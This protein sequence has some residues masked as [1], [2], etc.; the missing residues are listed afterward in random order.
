MTTRVAAPEV[1]RTGGDE[2]VD[3]G[4]EAAP[5][6]FPVL[7]I[8]DTGGV[9]VPTRALAMARVGYEIH[10]V[11]PRPSGIDA[12]NESVPQGGQWGGIRRLEMAARL[13]DHGRRLKSAAGEVAHI[14][15]ASSLGAWLFVASGDRRPLVVSVMGGDILFDEQGNPSWAARWLIRQ[16]LRRADF[17]TAKSE[18]LVERLV[19]LGVPKARMEKVFWGVDKDL[20]RPGDANRCK[21]ELGLPE[22]SPVIFSPR[23]LKPFYRTDVLV[24]ALPDVLARFPNARL[25]ISEYEADPTYR[26]E[27]KDLARKLGIA[28]AVVFAGSIPHNRMPE[29][30]NAADVAVG[31][32]PSDGFPQTVFEAM[33]CGTPN[34]VARLTRYEE[35]LTDGESALFVDPT[36]DGVARGILSVLDD[37]ELTERLRRNGF[38]I[39]REKA[40]LGHEAARVSEIY[41]RLHSLAPRPPLPLFTRLAAWALL[42][43]LAAR[44]FFKAEP[45]SRATWSDPT[46]GSATGAR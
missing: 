14:H 23:I 42:G 29:Y 24:Q 17:V 21:R 19:E 37:Q 2:V 12:L 11:T 36:G 46:T 4:S 10:A 9:H 32:P 5:A 27:I 38:R 41:Q 15:Y 6:H 22:E 44:D 26:T 25:V 8:G 13:L 16:V 33:A 43:G 3:V 31:I 34:V 39:V 18:Y 45:S 20:F 7:V 1:K 28:G 35:V 40:D 30:Y